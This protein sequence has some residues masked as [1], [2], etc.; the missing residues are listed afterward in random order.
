[1]E[2]EKMTVKD[3]LKKHKP[4]LS[5][6]RLPVKTLEAFKKLAEEKY[7]NDFGWTLQALMEE[8]TRLSV[9]SSILN[10]QYNLSERLAKL[11]KTEAKNEKKEIKT[12]SGK[13]L[14]RGEEEDGQK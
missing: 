8:V 6:N 14:K 11:E 5:I 3:F 2:E 4:V 7:C 12:I 1:M 13:V 9:L 10:E